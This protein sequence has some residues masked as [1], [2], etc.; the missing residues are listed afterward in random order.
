MKATTFNAVVAHAASALPVVSASINKLTDDELLA[1]LQDNP[2]ATVVSPDGKHVVS[3]W[4]TS[5]YDLLFAQADELNTVQTTQADKLAAFLK[6][7]YGKTA[8]TFKQFTADRAALKTLAQFRGLVDD[9]W[10]RKPYNLAIKALYGAL[11]VAMTTAAIAKRAARAA[12]PKTVAAPVGAPAGE[13]APR[14]SSVSEQVEQMV[15]KF[16]V[17]E[18]MQ[19]ITAILKADAKT[20]TDAIALEAIAKHYKA[21]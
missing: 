21:A 10:V 16:G 12:A 13:V 1:A 17:F 9:Q 20:H 19:A 6:A 7:H 3:A 4:Q 11:P 8:P 5:L 14:N 2:Q 15:A 18:T